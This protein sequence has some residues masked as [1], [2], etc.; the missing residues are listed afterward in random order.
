MTQHPDQIKKRTQ[1]EMVDRPAEQLARSRTA[2]D[3]R[4]DENGA[5]V[6]RTIKRGKAN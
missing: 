2:T 1:Q 4:E 3:R 6:L 5:A